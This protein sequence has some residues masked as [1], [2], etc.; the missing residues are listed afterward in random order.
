MSL[1]ARGLASDS[2]QKSNDTLHKLTNVVS[3]G[4]GIRKKGICLGRGIPVSSVMNPKE[5]KHEAALE[6]QNVQQKQK[7][8]KIATN[9]SKLQR[10][11]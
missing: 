7:S 4:E 10:R 3:S 2:V 1:V 6:S 9:I 11:K 5:K 8:L